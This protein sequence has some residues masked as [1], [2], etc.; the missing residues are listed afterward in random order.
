M[1]ITKVPV[2]INPPQ[3]INVIVEVPLG[4]DP[5]KY[6]FDKESG[7]IFVDRFLH[8]AMFYPCNYG[9]VPHTLADDGDPVDVLVAG[10]VPVVPGA[11]I[12]CRPVGVLVMEDEA[13]QDE[14]V[15]AVPVDKLH[16]YYTDV[17]SYRQLPEIL[18]EQIAHFF[19][20]YKDLEPN[21]WVKINHW[22][23]AEEAQGMIAKAIAAAKAKE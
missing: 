15:L 21:K 13:G 4:G 22:G 10:P 2:G 12:R 8:T 23:D 5:V 7:A 11:V 19:E 14:K 1:D 20:H 9:F 3:D 17:E 18:L 6:E 16:P